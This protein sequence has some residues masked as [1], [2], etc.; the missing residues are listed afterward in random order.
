VT[1]PKDVVIAWQRGQRTNGR[2]ANEKYLADDIRLVLP[3]SDPIV[4][5]ENCSRHFEKVED[6]FAPLRESTVDG[7]YTVIISEGDFVA[8]RFRWYGETH[9]G[10]LVDLFIFNLYRVVAGKIDH[11]E[12]HY[13]T[14]SRAQYSYAYQVDEADRTFNPDTR[15]I[16]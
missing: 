3:G 13:D 16:S 10:Q 7:P 11:F 14:L 4:G 9:D 6:S 12:E 5:K 15:V 2:E 8:H 1:D